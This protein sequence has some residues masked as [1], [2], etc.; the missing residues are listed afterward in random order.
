MATKI[1]CKRTTPKKGIKRKVKIGDQVLDGLMRKFTRLI[2]GGYCKRCK[3]FVGI[4]MIEVAHLYRRKRKT[5]RWD[6]RNVWPLCRNDTKTGK[7]GCHTII[8]NDPIELT[9]FMYDVL[10]KEDITDLQRL[11][12]LTLKEYPIDRLEIKRILEEKISL[13]EAHEDE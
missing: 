13:L 3:S 5:V 2:S 10:S 11:A 1:G 7:V 6:I 12:N 4:D 9:S 8:D